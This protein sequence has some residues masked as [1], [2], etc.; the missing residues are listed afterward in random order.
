MGLKEFVEKHPAAVATVLV[1]AS[2]SATSAVIGYLYT[3]S[4]DAKELLHEA[5][6]TELRTT[7]GTKISDLQ[8]RLA[9]IERGIGGSKRFFDIT[10]IS[11]ASESLTTLSD[12]Y[13]PF[14]DGKFFV[15]VPSSDKWHYEEITEGNLV[16]ERLGEENYAMFFPAF[17]RNV[18]DSA[19]VDIWRHSESSTIRLPLSKPYRHKVEGGSIKIKLFPYVTVQV[20]SHK[21]IEDIMSAMFMQIGEEEKKLDEAINKIAELSKALEDQTDRSDEMKSLE[22]EN[23]MAE[24][25]KAPIIETLVDELNKVAFDDISGFFVFSYLATGFR[26]ATIMEDT[27]Y[28]ILSL[29]KKGNVAYLRSQFLFGTPKERSI[30]REKIIMDQEVFVIATGREIIVVKIEVPSRHGR[31]DAFQW[32]AAWLSGLRVL[33]SG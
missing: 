15:D 10:K 7:F 21:Q 1:V 19:A 23:Q 13:H 17:A 2:V 11:I 4:I 18:M 26:F 29:Q 25:E 24:A 6:I 22:L 32:I 16:R 3:R 33:L 30:R 5:K 27:H 28:K 8:R 12:T 9:S 31:H 20:M 14:R